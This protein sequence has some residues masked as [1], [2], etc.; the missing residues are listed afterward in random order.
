MEAMQSRE[1]NMWVG[2]Y[3]NRAAIN[4]NKLGRYGSFKIIFISFINQNDHFISE[5]VKQMY[6]KIKLKLFLVFVIFF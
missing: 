1:G 5:K 3:T 2:S 4:K 6:S